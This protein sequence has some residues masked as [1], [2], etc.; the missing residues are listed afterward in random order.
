MLETERVPVRKSLKDLL[1]LLIGCLCSR[2]IGRGP[3][4]RLLKI[5]PPEKGL[6]TVCVW[7]QSDELLT[8]QYR[9]VDCRHAF[10]PALPSPNNRQVREATGKMMH[11]IGGI[12]KLAHELA[13]DITGLV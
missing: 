4:V 11:I 13:Y 1:S 7:F 9:F 3:A 10:R 2:A 8:Q 12:R 5:K 6:E